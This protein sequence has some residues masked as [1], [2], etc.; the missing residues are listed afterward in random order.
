M[1][2]VMCLYEMGISAISPSSESTFLPDKVLEQLQKRFKRI[3]ILFD[4][5]EA[6]VNYLRKMSL[7]TGLEGLLIHK[8]FK[9][10]DV[11]D[12][13]KANDFDSQQEKTRKYNRAETTVRHQNKA[14]CKNQ[15]G[16]KPIRPAVEGI[17]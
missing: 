14:V 1:K 7:K 2:D 11:S 10:K 5:D 3:I 9:A 17:F 16:C 6:G 8:K 12:A 4:R 13:I 15:R